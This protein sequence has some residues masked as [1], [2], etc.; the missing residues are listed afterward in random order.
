VDSSLACF[1]GDRTGDSSTGGGDLTAARGEIG[2]G[3]GDPFDRW[4]GDLGPPG[5]WLKVGLGR[6]GGDFAADPPNIE[7]ALLTDAT[8]SRSTFVGDEGAASAIVP[9]NILTGDLDPVR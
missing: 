8:G 6:V 1:L 5:V 3:R 2:P 7:V 9:S 4:T